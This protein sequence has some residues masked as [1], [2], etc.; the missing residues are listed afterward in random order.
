MKNKILLLVAI[1]VIAAVPLTMAAQ[2]TDDKGPLTKITFVHYAKGVAKPAKPVKQCY[3]FLS[4][5]AKLKTMK[6]LTIHPDLNAASI[7]DSTAEWDSHT[8]KS[9][10]DGYTIDSTANWDETAPDGRN[11]FSYGN[12]PEPGVIAVT[13]VWGYFYGPLQTR[14]IV[15]FDVMFDTDFV[16][17]DALSDP[18]LI[19]TQNIATHEI[20]HGVGLSDL[21]NS[22]CSAETMYGYS[23]Y[24]ETSKRDL[25]NGDIAGLQKLYGA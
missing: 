17:G 6:N 13:N 25:Y 10:F 14:E 16:W 19:D 24:G 3:A 21:Y 12:Y 11:E 2:H 9:L 8:S 5:G 1:S 7:M 18:S 15:E 20:G 23:N 4:N 22:V